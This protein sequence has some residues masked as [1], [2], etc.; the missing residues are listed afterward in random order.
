[1]DTVSGEQLDELRLRR[2]RMSVEERCDQLAAIRHG[3]MSI[4]NSA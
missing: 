2:D 1:V 4:P 3:R